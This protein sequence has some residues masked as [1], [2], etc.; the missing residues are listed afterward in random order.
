VA[1]AYVSDESAWQGTHP[2]PASDAIATHMQVTAVDDYARPTRIRDEGDRARPDDVCTQIDYTSSLAGVPLVLATP[3]AVRTVDCANSA[4]ILGGVRFRYDGLPEGQV[5]IGLPSSQVV[6]RYDLGTGALLEQIEADTLTRDVFGNMVGIARTRPDGASAHTTLTYDPFGLRTV[7]SETTATGLASP[8]VTEIERDSDTLQ[9]LTVTNPYGATTYSTYD[10]FDRRTRLSLTMPGNATH[11]VLADTAYLGFDGGNTGRSVQTRTYHQWTPEAQA[12]TVDP[13]TVTTATMQLDEFGRTMHSIVD[14]GAGYGNKSLIVNSVVYDTLG[15]PRFAADPFPADLFG[16]HYG[17]TF[18]YRADGRFECAIAGTGPQTLATTDPAVD[19]YPR[20]LS[21]LYANG[22]L[23]VRAQGPN[24]IAPSTPQSGAY[25]ERVLSGTG[26]LLNSS[27]KQGAMELSRAEYA[28]DRLGGLSQLTRFADAQARTGRATW[29]WTRDSLGN[30]LNTTEPA[31]VAR[32]Y[33]RD[34]WNNITAVAWRDSTGIVAVDR[35]LRFS[36]DGLSRLRHSD[37]T[38]NGQIVPDAASVYTYDVPANNPAQL[39]TGFLLGHLSFARTAGRSAYFGYD[40]LGRRTA[41]SHSDDDDPGFYA[42]RSTL[43]PAREVQE[44]DLLLPDHTGSPERIVYDYDSA[45]RL[46][47][48]RY[49][50]GTDTLEAWRAVSVDPFGHITEAKLGNGVTQLDTYRDGGRR[51]LLS[52][53]TQ[54]NGQSQLVLYDGYDG[55]LRLSGTS[56][57]TA[58]PGSSSTLTTT[59]AYDA[60]NALARAVAQD[61]SGIVSDMSYTYDG[62]GNIATIATAGAGTV[63]FR[64]FKFDRDRLCAAVA[65]NAP[66]NVPCTYGYDALGSVRFNNATGELF[67]YDGQGRLSEAERGGRRAFFEYGPLEA[68]TT[69]RIVDADGQRRERLY[70]ASTRVDF[71]DPAGAPVNAGAE[72]FQ[73]YIERQIVSPAG[74]V[75]VAR[76]ADNGTRTLL[77]PMGDFQATRMVLGQAGD[78]LQNLAYAPF[79]EVADA[80]NPKSLAWWPYQW[81]GGRVLEGLGLVAMGKRVLDPRVGRFLQRDPV[82]NRRT[83]LSAHPY[84]FAMNNPVN[85]ADPSGL[86]CIGAQECSGGGG[87]TPINP[88]EFYFPWGVP[89]SGGK[90]QVSYPAPAPTIFP[91]P[92]PEEITT[93]PVWHKK[94]LWVRFH[95]FFELADELDRGNYDAPIVKQQHYS[96]EDLELMR[97]IQTWNNRVETWVAVA[98]PFGKGSLIKELFAAWEAIGLGGAPS[99][100][101]GAWT[102]GSSRGAFTLKINEVGGKLYTTRGVVKMSDFG[103]LIKEAIARGET[104]NIISGVHGLKNGSYAP[105]FAF[106]LA[107]LQEF[108]RYEN[109]NFYD[110]NTMTTSQITGLV[111]GPQTTFGGFCYSGICLQPYMDFP[112]P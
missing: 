9:P 30:V 25:D 109:V 24:E 71:L 62:L 106:Y 10:G 86:Q 31:G 29:T 55:S 11:Y 90:P 64:P 1:T 103:D 12:G 99:A 41:L 95:E 19:R 97:S 101:R 91:S 28:Y 65:P 54:A 27:R 68:P 48:V 108:G 63:E 111:N 96:D 53:R 52:R 56:Q 26:Q 60:R 100:F 75:A 13:A 46:R 35:G 51:E 45:R 18:T 67:E 14:L 70:G 77:Y 85:N 37:E 5:S 82:I 83:A 78:V 39:D 49:Q 89:P 8:L 105:Q 74:T 112:V 40:A 80:G 21:Y 76:R 84:A 66:D 16:P 6:E 107:D 3:H 23:L 34:A 87:P 17:V 7:R 20:C 102:S 79:G 2:Y 69:L 59:Y 22:T 15:R 50:D 33:T 4:R 58:T 57:I 110:F 43:G 73:R 98:S 36:Y 47:V 42:E 104:V 88:P 93:W 72:G 94:S 61:T 38:V 32:T 44:L 81:N 92:G